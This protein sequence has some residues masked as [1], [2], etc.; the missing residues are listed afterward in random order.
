MFLRLFGFGVSFCGVSA[1]DCLDCCLLCFKSACSDAWL[2]LVAEATCLEPCL[3]VG[4]EVCLTG[5]EGLRFPDD[6]LCRPGEE[7]FNSSVE[8][9]ARLCLIG[10]DGLRMLAGWLTRLCRFGEDG[11]DM[12]GG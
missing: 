4:A 2:V 6:W 3:F 11:F 8:D 9:R 1:S 12:L 5:E 10:E 7:G